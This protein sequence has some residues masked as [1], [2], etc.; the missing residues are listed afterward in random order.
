MHCGGGG[1]ATRGLL[2]EWHGGVGVPWEWWRSSLP[3]RF[4]EKAPWWALPLHG[5]HAADDPELLLQRHADYFARRLRLESFCRAPL[6]LVATFAASA[7]KH[8]YELGTVRADPRSVPCA[9]D[10][11]TELPPNAS[12]VWE[13]EWVHHASNATV[14]LVPPPD[15]NPGDAPPPSMAYSST[16]LLLIAAA[17]KAGALAPHLLADSVC[18]L[19]W[20][21]AWLDR[22]SAALFA[23]AGAVMLALVSSHRSV[24]REA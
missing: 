16:S 6:R 24:H 3:A 10:G 21:P 20:L 2:D 11:A 13:A 15:A 14:L 5:Q 9:R 8:E 18:S 19:F 17:L 4:G 1:A 7:H 12:R 23:V 22:R